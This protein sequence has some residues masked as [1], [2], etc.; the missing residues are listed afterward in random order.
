LAAVSPRRVP[1]EELVSILIAEHADIKRNLANLEKHI[2]ARNYEAASATLKALDSLFRQHIADEEAQV[3]RLLIDVH[4]VEGAD[5]AIVVFRQHRPIYALMK[6]VGE[7]AVV[8]PEA[9]ASNESKLR[10]L[11]DA[12]TRAEEADVFPRAL[13][14]YN[15][16]KKG[17]GVHGID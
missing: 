17:A 5:D 2:A 8:S 3:L 13:S 15:G 14:A 12:H 1:F 16:R 9:L 4:G 6:E 11:L 10:S 7:L